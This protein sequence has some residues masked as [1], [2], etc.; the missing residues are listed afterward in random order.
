MVWI[1]NKV[2]KVI[3]VALGSDEMKAASNV[4]MTQEEAVQALQKI[5]PHETRLGNISNG[6]VFCAECSKTLN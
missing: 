2:P 4:Y 5:C 6:R 3:S 1:I